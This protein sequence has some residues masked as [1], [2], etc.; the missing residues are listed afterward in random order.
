MPLML[1]TDQKSSDETSEVP[2]P[3]SIRQRSSEEGE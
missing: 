3:T 1:V 2:L